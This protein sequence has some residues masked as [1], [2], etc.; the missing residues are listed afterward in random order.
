MIDEN[1]YIVLSTRAEANN[2]ATAISTTIEELKMTTTIFIGLDTENNV[3]D[4]MRR[5]IVL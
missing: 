1:K 4:G 3:H 2:W 5:R